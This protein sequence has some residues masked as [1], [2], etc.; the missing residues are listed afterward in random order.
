VTE[1]LRQAA[2]ISI[3]ADGSEGSDGYRARRIARS[4][5]A[6]RR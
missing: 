4:I 3:T 1:E 5:F 2:V 6:G